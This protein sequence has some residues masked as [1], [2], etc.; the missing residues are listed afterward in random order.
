MLAPFYFPVIAL[1]RRRWRTTQTDV[2]VAE[3]H[4]IQTCRTVVSA[5]GTR[6]AAHVSAGDLKIAFRTF[7]SSRT[8]RVRSTFGRTVSFG[9]T[10]ANKTQTRRTF[11]GGCTRIAKLLL[12]GRLLA[13]GCVELARSTLQGAAVKALGFAGFAREVGAVAFFAS[14][15]LT[16]AAH[17][18]L[19]TAAGIE[20]T[21]SGTP[22]RATGEAFG[23]TGL[24]VQVGSVTLF[25]RVNR[26]IP[27]LGSLGAG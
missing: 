13:T 15:N 23:L 24:V 18:S 8:I 4:A 20:S 16:V 19:R 7:G 10:L 3:R 11:G 6:P 12:G 26:S 17:R 1:G 14:V 9:I 27:T 5:W 25:T 22:Q 2:A 21:A